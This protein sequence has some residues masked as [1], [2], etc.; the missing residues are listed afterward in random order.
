MATKALF[1]DYDGTIITNRTAEMPEDIPELFRRL[2]DEGHLLFLNTGRTQSILDPRCRSLPFDGKILGCGSSVE[3]NG[4]TLY[5]FRLPPAH[6]TQIA[7]QLREL[8]IEGFL[9]GS[10]VLYYT[11]RF[12]EPH[13]ADCLARYLKNGVNVKKASE[14]DEP[15]TKMFLHFPAPEILG[16][17]QKHWAGIFDFI[18]RGGA[19]WELV[20]SGHSKATGMRL[21][22]ERLELKPENCYA[23]GDSNNDRPMLALVPN[24]ALIGAGNAELR[25]IVRYVSSGVLDGGLAEAVR[26]FG[27]VV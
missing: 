3:L 8:G 1:F 10:Q 18:D 22:M 14:L 2:K 24:S 20:P 17:F 15:F 26:A 11:D 19:F 4:K 23:F 25:Q 13:L 9:E 6:C 27:L 21:V 5:E 12:T 7:E 16:R